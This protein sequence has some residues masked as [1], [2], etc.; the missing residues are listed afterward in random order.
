MS[1]NKKDK[2]NK[3]MKGHQKQPLTRP[4]PTCPQ[5]HKTKHQEEE[6]SRRN[7]HCDDGMVTRTCHSFV[8]LYEKQD[9]RKNEYSNDSTVT[10]TC[11]SFVNLSEKKYVCCMKS[12]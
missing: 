5:E 2:S 3:T 9:K 8:G 4:S 10:H 1:R 6:I 7:K 12:S 11:W